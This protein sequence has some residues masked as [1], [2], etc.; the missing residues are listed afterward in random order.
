MP[1]LPER[2]RG[3]PWQ[4]ESGDRGDAALGVLAVELGEPPGLLVGDAEPGVRH[5]QRPEDPLGEEHVEELLPR[6][7]FDEAAE[8]I[9]GDGVVPLGARLELKGQ[10]RVHVAGPGQ[11]RAGRHRRLQTGVA[12]ERV[13]GVEW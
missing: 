1:P 3:R 9:G 6:H 2:K 8:H 10:A 12:V 11:V 5:P 7:H 4:R 13:D